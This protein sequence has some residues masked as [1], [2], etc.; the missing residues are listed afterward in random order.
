MGLPSEPEPRGL[1]CPLN[2][3]PDSKRILSP[4]WKT[5]LLTLAR[6]FQ[7]P[8]TESPSELSFPPGDTK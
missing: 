6:V 5:M 2:V 1:S 4:G 3:A 7:A 8:L